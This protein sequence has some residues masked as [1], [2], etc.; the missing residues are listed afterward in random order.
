MTSTSQ[1]CLF[2]R[3]LAGAAALA[4][5]LAAPAAFA[6]DAGTGLYLGGVVSYNRTN[7]LGSKID[8]ALANQGYASG[9][10]ADSSS[11]NGGLRLGYQFNRNFALE[12]SYD[13]VG[14]QGV[15]SAI[16]GDSASGTWKAHGLGLHAV[17]I[18]PINQQLS[19]FGKVGVEQWHSTLDL[20]ST[21]G[22]PTALSTGDTT[23]SLAL[24]AGVSYALTKSVD[25]T[26]EWMYYNRVGD[27]ATTGRTS[28]NQFNVGLRYH[29]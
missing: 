26:A 17:G 2:V 13:R 15:Q 18:A 3:T 7:D 16:G 21:V 10:S 23:S 29:F 25:A 20:A 4:A 19:V 11:T 28:L 12:A 27:N 14:N 5:T 24:G 9:S 22:G 1:P 8:N 6:A